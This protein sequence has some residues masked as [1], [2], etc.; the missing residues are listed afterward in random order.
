MS[1]LRPVSLRGLRAP[2]GGVHL[3]RRSLGRGPRRFVAVTRAQRSPRLRSWMPHWGP[4]RNP[5]AAPENHK[6]SRAPDGAPAKAALPAIVS[7][8]LVGL[9]H[10]VDVVLALVRAALLLLGVEELVRKPLGHRLLAALA[11]EQDQ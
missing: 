3:G 2:L 9:G 10:A 4:L 8:G 5:C 7:E 11:R 1:G 6:P